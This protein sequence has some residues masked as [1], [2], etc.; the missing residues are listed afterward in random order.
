MVTHESLP[1][2]GTERPD[3][4]A[5]GGIRPRSEIDRAAARVR[6]A[7][8][9]D[10]NRDDIARVWLQTA[11]EDART[12]FPDL[13]RHLRA[14]ISGLCEVFRDDDWSLTQT[15]VDGLAERRART[16]VRL[17]LGMQRALL[18]GRHAIRPLYQNHEYSEACDEE[19]LDAL[20]ECVFRFS[21]SYQGIRLDSETERVHSRLIKS[22]VMALEA[23]DP[24][25]KG[26][27]ISVALL[28]HRIAELL[29]DPVDPTRAH[30][31]GL[32]HDVGKVGVPDSILLKPS[33][34]SDAE[35]KIMQAHPS[36]GAGILKPI[37]LYPE[38]VSAV[39][40]HHENY[41]GS[42]YPNGLA[43]EEIPQLGRVIRITDSF[44]AMTS[45]RAYR[46]S[47][48]ADQAVQQI[49][50][51]AGRVYDPDAVDVFV[52]VVGTPGVMR[53]LSLASL[54]IDLGEASHLSR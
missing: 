31:A 54:Q 45:T 48:T 40:T 2:G 10:H 11:G 24:Y 7:Q 34:L 37:N 33:V 21:E 30:L 13:E 20:H 50:G 26:H 16:G 29:R 39:L 28:S 5:E 27:S 51:L 36:I 25:T 4:I 52:K 49:L 23:R 15:V 18:A 32:L 17:E 14:L 1:L 6:L 46:S 12:R 44:D 41:D 47:Y 35:L 19:F 42:G 8:V 22:L 9:L 43:G 38:V 53:D 3:P